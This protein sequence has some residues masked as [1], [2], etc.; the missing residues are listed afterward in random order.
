ME[1]GQITEEQMKKFA[2]AAVAY[3]NSLE[4]TGKTPVSIQPDDSPEKILRKA[5]YRIIAADMMQ[6]IPK[7]R[8]TAMD[9][10]ARECGIP[11]LLMEDLKNMLVFIQ[12]KRD[13]FSM[14]NGP[15]FL[16]QCISADFGMGKGIAVQFNKYFDMKNR[17]RKEHPDYL[18]K[19]EDEG[20]TGD[21]IRIGSVLNLITKKRYWEKPDYESLKTALLAMRSIC[22]EEEISNIA[23]PMIGCGLDRLEWKKVSAMIAEVFKDDA[24]SIAVCSI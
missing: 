3:Y 16:A 19:W 8:N 21:C 6:E 23:M 4:N 20:K 15:Y 11:D 1:K 7:G 9:E 10:F 24:V 18:K 13:L 22:R 17:I 2:D 12:M 14:P 5:A